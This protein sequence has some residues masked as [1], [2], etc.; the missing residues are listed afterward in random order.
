MD[1]QKLMRTCFC[2]YRP[3]GDEFFVISPFLSSFGTGLTPNEAFE[4]F[5]EKVDEW[6]EQCKDLGEL[7]QP[8]PLKETLSLQ[9]LT[10]R[11]LRQISLDYDCTLSEAVDILAARHEYVELPAKQITDPELQ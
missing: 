3:E 7:P 9:P 10:V 8:T 5:E 11:T 2:V 4:S 6:I 1:K